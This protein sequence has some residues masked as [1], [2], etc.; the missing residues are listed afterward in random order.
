VDGTLKK[1]TRAGGHFFDKRDIGLVQKRS[2]HYG[3][4]QVHIKP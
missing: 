1:M 3:P 2:F 4:R